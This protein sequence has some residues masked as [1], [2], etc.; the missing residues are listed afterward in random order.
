MSLTALSGQKAQRFPKFST[1][2]SWL[3]SPSLLGH[4]R[5]SHKLMHLGPTD[6]KPRRD[7]C[8][9]GPQ[10]TPRVGEEPLGVQ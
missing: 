9:A 1:K 2:P 8:T 4:L 3:S 7:G 6:E 10:S 5:P